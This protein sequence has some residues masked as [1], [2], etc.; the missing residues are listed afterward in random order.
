MKLGK[1]L[2]GRAAAPLA[3]VLATLLAVS[4]AGAQQVV[5][6]MY[7]GFKAGTMDLDASGF[8]NASNWAVL[9]GF[10]LYDRPE[11]G[12]FALEGEYSRSFDDGDVRVAGARGE[13]DAET[14]ALY[15]AYRTGGSVFLKAK[16]GWANWDVNVSGPGTRAEGDDSDFSYGAGA[17]LRLSPRTGFEAEYT[18]IESDLSFVSLGF[19]SRF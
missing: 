8:D 19:F 11:T 3:I 9:L 1:A 5:N 10:T 12:S 16:A 18:V 14:L 17:G 4:P 2:P 7:F 15:G 6:P 13:W